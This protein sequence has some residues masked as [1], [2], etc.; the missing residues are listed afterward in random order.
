MEQH[1]LWAHSYERGQIK[2]CNQ[3]DKN[4]PAF[5][6]NTIPTFLLGI[7]ALWRL[8]YGKPSRFFIWR[9]HPTNEALCSSSSWPI[10]PVKTS[11][12]RDV[13]GNASRHDYFWSYISRQ[14]HSGSHEGGQAQHRCLYLVTKG[15]WTGLAD[16]MT[17]FLYPG[18][19]CADDKSDPIVYPSYSDLNNPLIN[20]DKLAERF[21]CWE[22][23]GFLADFD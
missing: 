7:Q 14:S 17:C 16:G 1:N 2:I 8:L 21:K 15:D 13:T 22:W 23:D 9:A 12:H 5:C 20:F 11:A 4:I 3:A 6:G 19:D 10:L 18:R